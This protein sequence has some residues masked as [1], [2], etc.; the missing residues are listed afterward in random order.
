MGPLFNENQCSAC[1]TDP[2][3]GGTGDQ[4]VTKATRY[5]V[6]T[7]CDLLVGSGG[8]NVRTRAIPILLDLGIQ[9]EEIPPEATEVARFVVPF[10]FG[11]G[12][13]EAIPPELLQGLADPED[14][15]GD[16]VSGRGSLIGLR[17]MAVGRQCRKASRGGA[18]RLPHAGL[19]SRE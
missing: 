10:L 17:S 1:H 4:F 6:A 3:P 16:G 13:A 2:G 11:L 19:A 5:A 15:D 12:L 18:P 8:E 9:G 14:R 7:G